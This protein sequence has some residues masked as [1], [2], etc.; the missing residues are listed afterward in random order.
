MQAKNSKEVRELHCIMEDL[1]NKHVQPATCTLLSTISL[2][3][4]CFKLKRKDRINADVLQAKSAIDRMLI[5]V[6]IQR[7]K[8]SRDG[9]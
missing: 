8:L 9:V 5:S 3:L 4:I 6:Y 7:I 2:I 1:V